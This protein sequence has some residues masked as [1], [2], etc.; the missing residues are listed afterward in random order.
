MIADA[1]VRVLQISD[2]PGNLH[3]ISCHTLVM[4]YNF[5][6]NNNKPDRGKGKNQ[7]QSTTQPEFLLASFFQLSHPGLPFGF[8]Q[9]FSISVSYAIYSWERKRSDVSSYG[10]ASQGH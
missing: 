1:R 2:L 8:D 10:F 7:R 9:G 5:N 4:L 6:N 3:G